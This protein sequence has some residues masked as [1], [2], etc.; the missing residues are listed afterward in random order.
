[1]IQRDD[2]NI[3]DIKTKILIQKFLQAINVLKETMKLKDGRLC[4][5]QNHNL[6][7]VCPCMTLLRLL[8]LWA[9]VFSF[10]RLNESVNVNKLQEL[11]HTMQIMELNSIKFILLEYE[12]TYTLWSKGTVSSKN[13]TLKHNVHIEKQ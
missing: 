4:A 13:K 8:N 9:T 1:M 11:E 12:G 10:V 5:S 6:I 7:V 2:Q 3:F